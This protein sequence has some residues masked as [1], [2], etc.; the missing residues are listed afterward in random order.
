VPWPGDEHRV[1]IVAQDHAIEVRIDEIDFLDTYPNAQA[2]DLSHAPPA[3]A[4]AAGHCPGDRFARRPDSAPHEG[5]APAK[6]WMAQSATVQASNSS[7]A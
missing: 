1:E 5:S 3:T 2:A 4:R 6:H 7:S